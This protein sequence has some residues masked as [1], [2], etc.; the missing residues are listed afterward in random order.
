MGRIAGL[1]IELPVATQAV[2]Q[3]GGQQACTTAHGLALAFSDL[4]FS[5]I[6]SFAPQFLIHRQQVGAVGGVVDGVRHVHATIQAD[7]V[8]IPAFAAQP[9]GNAGVG[10]GFVPHLARKYG[11]AVLVAGHAHGAVGVEHAWTSPRP[12]VLHDLELEARRRFVI[13]DDFDDIRF[14]L[15]AKIKTVPE[16]HA[17]ITCAILIHRYHHPWIGEEIRR[18]GAALQGTAQWNEHGRRFLVMVLFFHAAYQSRKGKGDCVAGFAY[19]LVHHQKIEQRAPCGRQ[20]VARHGGVHHPRGRSSARL[21]RWGKR[22]RC[23]RLC[24]PR[25]G[26]SHGLSIDKP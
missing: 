25:H 18:C 15:V 23:L 8:E 12:V 14:L 4:L 9:G 7:T 24:G 21:H 17:G 13:A 19:A 22:S 2:L 11:P 20:V 10:I 6:A 1:G 16:H 26:L 5:R 3:G